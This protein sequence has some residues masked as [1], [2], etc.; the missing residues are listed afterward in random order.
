MIAGMSPNDHDPQRTESDTFAVFT[1]TE[2][3]RAV[4]LELT[5]LVDLDSEPVLSRSISAAMDQ[6]PDVLVVDLSQ[7]E[8]LTSAGMAVL[9]G[10]HNRAQGQ[11]RFRIVASGNASLRPLQILG[12]TN[13]MS[14]FPTLDEALAAA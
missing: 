13:V 9:L 11:T 6:R 4:V 1:R 12:L 7:V 10:S 8:L 5:G 2:N 3:A 14:V